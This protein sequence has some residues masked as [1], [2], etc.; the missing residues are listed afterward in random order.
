M[1]VPVSRAVRDSL[2]PS[3][4]LGL[5]P[6]LKFFQCPTERHECTCA[7]V[8]VSATSMDRYTIRNNKHEKAQFW[9]RRGAAACVRAASQSLNLSD[10]SDPKKVTCVSA[11]LE[12]VSDLNDPL[13]WPHRATPATEPVGCGGDSRAL[14]QVSQVSLSS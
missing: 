7:L 6:K 5:C 4:L 12:G 11:H 10:L 14:P 3:C 1:I 13:L 8:L 9:E 2:T